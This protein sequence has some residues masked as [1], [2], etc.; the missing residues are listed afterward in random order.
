MTPIQLCHE[1]CATPEY[2]NQLHA[3]GWSESDVVE[4]G[5]GK[6]SHDE[7]AAAFTDAYF[8]ARKQV[9]MV[10]GASPREEK[11]RHREFRKVY[12]DEGKR[13]LGI[14]PM[15]ALFGAIVFIFGGPLGLV[16]AVAS[17]LLQHFMERDL[18]Q[19][20]AMDICAAAY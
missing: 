7:I 11:K 20:P 15:T 17:A 8:I 6:F 5:S 18:A 19:D 1:I 2:K 13:I 10:C 9:P 12:E 4:V 14:S 16:L 3:K